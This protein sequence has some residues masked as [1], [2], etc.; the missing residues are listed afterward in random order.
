MSGKK[1]KLVTKQVEVW[2][3]KLLGL[4]S[5]RNYWTW[6]W[7]PAL[8]SC[9]VKS[10]WSHKSAAL[11]LPVNAAPPVFWIYQPTVN[12]SQKMLTKKNTG[13]SERLT[14]LRHALKQTQQRGWTN[15]DLAST[16]T[17]FLG[18]RK[19]LKPKI[20]RTQTHCL[21]YI[22]AE[23]QL[24]LPWLTHIDPWPLW[25]LQSRK[26]Q[27]TQFWGSTFCRKESEIKRIEI[28]T[29][30]RPEKRSSWW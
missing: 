13:F 18:G 27:G 11:I 25:E 23:G 15:V 10:C 22:L 4:W 17:D 1:V 16:N 2:N 19:H 30:E 28:F 12:P 6:F 7:K 14:V 9:L 24:I 8:C 29:H 5:S 3:M 20:W 26:G 21:W